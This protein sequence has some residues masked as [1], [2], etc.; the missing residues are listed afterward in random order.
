VASVY[1]QLFLRSVLV[2]EGFT[3]EI[4]PNDTVDALRLLAAQ[5]YGMN[6]QQVRLF[7]KGMKV[8]LQ[9]GKTLEASGVKN[10]IEI[11][12]AQKVEKKGD[13]VIANL[14]SDLLSATK[15]FRDHEF[16]FI[17]I[18]SYDYGKNGREAVKRQQCNDALLRVC[19]ERRMTLTIFLID[20]TFEFEDPEP[21]QIYNLPGWSS[22]PVCTW[23][24]R[25]V[26]LY[27][28]PK[29]PNVS[30]FTYAAVIPEYD[31][32][33]SIND[34]AKIAGIEVRAGFRNA[35]KSKGLSTSCAV[36][37][38]FHDP[39]PKADQYF[40]IGNV[41]LLIECGFKLNP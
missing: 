35:I 22:H 10:E 6:P 1:W 2:A 28:H 8:E 33:N 37:G 11:W 3:V 14:R 24:E 19:T 36:S 18:G 25:K 16:V 29:Y 5:K 40:A 13:P 9:D 4:R 38:N 12:I 30:V 15:E 26:R 39:E 41:E 17:S 20:P 27:N 32:I 34:R 23:A 7:L 31:L 21:P